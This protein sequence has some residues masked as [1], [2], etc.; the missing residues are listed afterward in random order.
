MSAAGRAVSPVDV[1]TVVE[2]T[3]EID[4]P[5]AAVYDL[6]TTADGLCAWWGVAAS[7][8]VRVGGSIEVDIDG[9]HVMIGEFLELDPPHRLAMTFGWRDGELP[10]GASTVEVTFDPRAGGGTTVTLRH[11]GLP[12]D[13]V[14]SHVRGWAHFLGEPFHRA[15]SA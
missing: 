2:L 14:D 12:V 13:F 8:D 6:W 5:P 10:P 15:G 4:A 9:E 1:T 7:V 3:V 11:A